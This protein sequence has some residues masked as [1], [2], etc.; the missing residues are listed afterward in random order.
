[1]TLDPFDMYGDFSAKLVTLL[2]GAAL[3]EEEIALRL[4]IE[5][6]Q[7][8]VWLKRACEAGL[9]EKQKKPVRYVLGRQG[10]LC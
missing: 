9:V 2:T 7:A 1:M 3:S 6:S 8:K 5:K 10:S 4:F